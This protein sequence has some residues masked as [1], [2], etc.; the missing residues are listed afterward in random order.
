MKTV[1]CFWVQLNCFPDTNASLSCQLYLSIQFPV[2]LNVNIFEECLLLST[3]HGENMSYPSNHSF[4]TCSTRMGCVQQ[5][6]SKSQPLPSW[7]AHRAPTMRIIISGY[8]VSLPHTTNIVQDS[9]NY[10]IR[11]QESADREYT[12]V[13]DPFK[14]TVAKY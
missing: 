11:S 4:T 13:S 1:S 8:C 2:N 10:A 14:G 12:F 5:T 3:I 9:S 7:F 6:F